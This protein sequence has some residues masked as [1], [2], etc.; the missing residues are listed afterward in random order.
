MGYEDLYE[1][2]NTG[3]IRSLD[4]EVPHYRGGTRLVKGK[5]LQPVVHHSGYVIV[6]LHRDGKQRTPRIHKLVA[7]AFLG[8][9]PEG[10]EVRHKNGI[11]SDPRL[12]NLMYGTKKQNS[13]DRRKH[14][15]DPRGVKNPNSKLT[16]EQ[17]RM[18]RNSDLPRVA[19][20]EMFGVQVPAIW[21]IQAG[22]SWK[23]IA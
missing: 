6:T 1:V 3:H 18:I 14:G 22:R 17:V 20:A 23:E 4:R 7:E 16:E 13:A 15:T 12:V 10:Q 9:C 21:K 11:R 2:S 8:P 19:L 5:V